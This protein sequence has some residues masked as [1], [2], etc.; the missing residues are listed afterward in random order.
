MKKTNTQ[1]IILIISTAILVFCAISVASAGDIWQPTVSKVAFVSLCVVA[2]YVGWMLRS[3]LHRPESEN[4]AERIAGLYKNISEA[5]ASA[6]AAKDFY[7]QD[8]VKRV[9]AICE[10]TGKAMK[11]SKKEL[12]SLRIAALVH[13]AGKL[14]V[15]EYIMLKPGPLDPEEFSK[16]KNHTAIGAKILEQVNCPVDIVDMVRHHHESF[17]G[18][19]YP[20]NISGAQIPMGARIIAVAEVYDA[21]VSERCYKE[22]WKPVEAMKY[23]EKL[24]G[25]QFD[26]EVVAA[27]LSMAPQVEALYHPCAISESERVSIKKTWAAADEIARANQEL[28]SLFEIAQ[29]LSS[30]LELD[31]VL[32]LLA[33]RTRRLMQVTTCVVFLTDE[34]NPGYLVAKATAGRHVE[35]TG[36]A[37]VEVGSG[38]VGKAF[39]QAKPY[40]GTF[41]PN[42]LVIGESHG[43]EFE[44]KS[45]LI[46]PI[47]SLGQAIGAIA[48]YDM[49]L[50][51]FSTDSR[52]LL[53]SIAD[54]AALAILN[55]CAF[56][57][58]RDS[59]MKDP[60]T[61]LH[62]TRHLHAHLGDEIRRAQRHGSTLSVLAID[63]DNFK[64][65]NDSLGHQVGDTVL[66][67][68]AGIFLAQLREYDLVARVGGDEFVIALPGTPAAEAQIIA[69][70]IRHGI[71]SYA[72][73]AAKNSSAPLGASI[74]VATYPNDGTDIEALLAAA[75]AAMY[76]DKRSHKHG[77]KAA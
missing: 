63:L 7:E 20:D 18:T 52:H 14:G 35:M 27:F 16:M 46:V 29:T 37:T 22:G 60:L 69:E 62:N 55:A 58:V 8:H 42:E 31:E 49:S 32:G 26:P 6:I 1:F 72:R 51:T 66:Q 3:S 4:E 43:E 57:Q 53:T 45:C 44:F 65:V 75:D 5:L 47:L 13:D 74:G 19:G 21:L 73:K 71:E 76:V 77:H 64:A 17:N 24:S 67:Q 70:R 9:V 68:A 61:G 10:L 33:Q 48:L 11:F 2:C 50:N 15:P 39:A 54:R 23:I 30:T 40:V 25:T 38:P 36:L 34:S 56:E 28:I 12:D 41:D 59:S